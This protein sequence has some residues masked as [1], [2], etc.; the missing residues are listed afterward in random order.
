MYRTFK[1]L[2]NLFRQQKTKQWSAAHTAIV[3]AFDLIFL[4]LPVRTAML[5]TTC[6]AATSCRMAPIPPRTS[7]SSIWDLPLRQERSGEM[8][9]MG[10]CFRSYLIMDFLWFFSTWFVDLL[11]VGWLVWLNVGWLVWLVGWLE[12]SWEVCLPRFSGFPEAH[13]NHVR[14]SPRQIAGR[15]CLE[16]PMMR[17]KSDCQQKRFSPR[18]RAKQKSIVCYVIVDI[19]RYDI[20]HDIE[21]QMMRYGYEY[22]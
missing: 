15:M 20:R 8:P 22:K 9:E 16:V 6:T 1:D 12:R 5:I 10:W 19:E 2:S 17:R 7:A 18:P 3:T 11:N 4:G 21:I 14:G 13:P